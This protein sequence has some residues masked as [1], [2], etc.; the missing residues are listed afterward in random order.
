MRRDSGLAEKEEEYAAVHEHR[1]ADGDEHIEVERAASRGKKDTLAQA[2]AEEAI[3][4]LVESA[5]SAV[6]VCHCL[7]DW[8]SQTMLRCSG[9]ERFNA[10]HGGETK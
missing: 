7:A 6:F 1:Q 4:E 8:W 2:Q 10:Q 9:R 3:A 5:R